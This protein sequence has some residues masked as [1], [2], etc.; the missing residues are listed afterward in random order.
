MCSSDLVTWLITL[1]L[2]E[3][4]GLGKVVL[5]DWHVQVRFSFVLFDRIISEKVALTSIYLVVVVL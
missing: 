3:F 1:V 2:I 4:H 5:C